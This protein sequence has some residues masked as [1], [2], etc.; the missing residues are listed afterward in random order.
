PGGGGRRF[1]AANQGLTANVPARSSPRSS[2]TR[3]G[4]QGRA[5][6]RAEGR[7]GGG[8]P[9]HTRRSG[10]GRGDGVATQHPPY[11][12]DDR[13]R[14]VCR[15]G[16]HLEAGDGAV[17]Q[18]EDVGERAAGVDGDDDGVVGGCV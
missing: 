4:R 14:R 9:T 6:S 17:A 8:S 3:A 12:L 11:P 13:P 10:G 16:R 5:V 2:P 15:R 18:A 1:V 7:G